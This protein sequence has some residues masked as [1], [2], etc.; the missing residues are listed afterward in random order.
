MR[1]LIMFYAT[2]YT[3]CNGIIGKYQGTHR[4]VLTGSV[5]VDSV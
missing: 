2:H 5:E 1:I 3:L 4:N